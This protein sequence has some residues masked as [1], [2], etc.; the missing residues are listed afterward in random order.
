M[1]TM[2]DSY[3]VKYI[4]Q[5]ISLTERDAAMKGQTVGQDSADT[6]RTVSTC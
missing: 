2:L 1:E 3:K 4:C 6:L 5:N